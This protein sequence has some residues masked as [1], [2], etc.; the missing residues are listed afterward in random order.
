MIKLQEGKDYV[1]KTIRVTALDDV[2]YFVLE[3]PDGRRYLLNSKRYEGYEITPGKDVVCRVDKIN[4][5]GE[6]FLEPEHPIYREGERYPFI[7]EG[8][9]SRIDKQGNS[10]RVIRFSD[11]LGNRPVL[12]FS[13]FGDNPP[14]PG[15]RVNL[16]VERIFKGR[17]LFE[18]MDQERHS[19][20]EEDLNLY[21][22]I[23]TDIAGGI[24]EKNYFLVKGDDSVQYTVRADYYMH[25]GL[26]EGVR[27][28]G[29]FV[30]YKEGDEVRVEPENPWYKPGEM[31]PFRVKEKVYLD[32]SSQVITLLTDQYGY[33]HSIEGD[34]VAEV[35]GEIIL[36]VERIRKGWPL[37]RQV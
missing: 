23:V 10:Q 17:I 33:S 19:P 32:G 22:F 25:Y 16:K 30:R 36:K 13:W 26:K 28:K 37:L 2:S 29:R 12:H 5:K 6:Y 34:T 35:G 21:E 14:E 31:Y 3:G 27:F 1:F 18:G 4:C 11:T 15:E 7:A 24:D 8:Y 20:H 9:E